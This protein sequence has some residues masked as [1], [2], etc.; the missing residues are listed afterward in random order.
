MSRPLV[1]VLLVVPLLLSAC[2]SRP[3][4]EVDSWRLIAVEELDDDERAKLERAVAARDALAATLLARVQSSM[5][6][7]G[8]AATVGACALEASPMTEQIAEEHGV[9]IGRTSHRLRNPGNTPPTWAAERVAAAEG[10]IAYYRGPERSFGLLSPI[11]TG[12]PC[13][14]C[15]GSEE[16]LAPGIEAVLAD[17]YPEDQAVGFAEGDLRGWFWVEVESR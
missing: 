16:Q 12:T 4:E 15:H 17:R 11:P 10:G 3:A 5:Q 1:V 2:R 6:E 13:L 7:Q 9:R 14:R 8:P